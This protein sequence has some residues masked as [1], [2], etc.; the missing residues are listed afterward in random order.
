M[1]GTGIISDIP[2][3]DLPPNALSAGVNVRFENGKI[4]RAP[5]FK[6]VHEYT[7]DD[8]TPVF[9]FSIPP[10][11]NGAED[12][13]AINQDGSQI[14]SVIGQTV[15][16]YTPLVPYTLGSVDDT[17]TH[18]FLGNVAYFNRKT[19]VPFQKRPSD[20]T[21]APLE[22]WDDD[23]R[24]GALR[25]YKDFLIALNVRKGAVEY[26]SMVKWSDL[27][28]FGGPPPSWDV[29]STTNSAGEN[30][31]NEMREPLVDGLSLRDSFILYGS[32]EVWIM[33]YIGGNFLFRF[34]KLFKESGVIS[35]NCAVEIEGLHYVFGK[36]DIW[37]HDGTTKK[38]I[39]HG[40][41]R[42]Y[43]FKNLVGLHANRCFVSHDPKL[44]EIHFNYPSSDP[45]V[46]F[47]D[48][49]TGCNRSAVYN[50]KRDTWTFYDMPNVTAFCLAGIASGS[51]YETDPTL[52]YPDA[53]DDYLPTDDEKEQH[54]MFVSRIDD[55]M[56][57][58]KNRILGL[59]LATR[60]KLDRDVSSEA[61]KEAFAE[62]TFMDLDESGA[63]IVSYKALH[64][65][66]PQ[67]ELEGD[68]L[69]EFQFAASHFS[70]GSLTWSTRQTFDPAVDYKLDVRE[71]GRYL[72]WRLYYDGTNDFG[73]SGLDARVT[74]RGHQ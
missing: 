12:I 69:P 27:S 45:L 16:D 54:C 5:V 50:Y 22:N 46:A 32:T 6:E 73:F 19:S 65:I 49:T 13:V 37:L 64:E 34:R 8:F 2:P 67:L 56:G 23:W 44:N 20:L 72:A 7:D 63:P 62:R 9:A 24:C 21:F 66:Y 38:S 42:D 61:L 58:T 30:I 52:L 35:A 41:N 10:I 11:S 36:N 29:A 39:I 47:E 26:P 57:L 71:A 70:K 4:T 18:T 51:T 68:A 14:L 25:S 53:S 17:Y 1:G 15:L 60:G 43:V 3:Y 59:D 74:Q 40:T 55:G 48:P 33:D 31:L 28:S